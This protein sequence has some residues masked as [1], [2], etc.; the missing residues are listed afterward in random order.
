MSEAT[1]RVIKEVPPSPQITP[2]VSEPQ[3][4]KAI[5]ERVMYAVTRPGKDGRTEFATFNHD[6]TTDIAEADMYGH[7]APV[8]NVHQTHMHAEGAGVSRIV[9]AVYA[10]D[11]VFPISR[12]AA[13]R[14]RDK[15]ARKDTII[16]AQQTNCFGQ[17]IERTAPMIVTNANRMGRGN[18]VSNDIAHAVVIDPARG[19]NDV[20]AEMTGGIKVPHTPRGIWRDP[21]TFS[22]G[23][24]MRVTHIEP[25]G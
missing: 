15:S 3:H 10:A 21:Q 8:R 7:D 22:Y 16:M 25:V 19:W 14:A 13:D 12:L 24:A 11:T 2:P 23:P 20:R 4:P 6:W 18:E 1:A 17:V 9:M 5:F